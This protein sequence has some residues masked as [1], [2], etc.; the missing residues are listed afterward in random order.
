M[1]S[2]HGSNPT[3]IFQ[4][5]MD[6][7]GEVLRHTNG[8]IAHAHGVFLQGV[9]LRRKRIVRL[10]QRHEHN[11]AHRRPVSDCR[12]NTGRLW[13]LQ[14]RA[15][16]SLS[17]VFSQSKH[18]LFPFLPSKVVLNGFWTNSLSDVFW[19]GLSQITRFWTNLIPAAV[20]VLTSILNYQF[21]YLVK[22]ESW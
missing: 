13:Q 17:K 12:Q 11:S 14:L 9:E 19:A 22:D 21:Y 3:R 8:Q 1:T 10:R 5:R 2:T 15:G 6:L 20:P 18:T 7:I 4:A 16:C